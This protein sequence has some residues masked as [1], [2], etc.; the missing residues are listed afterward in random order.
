MENYI[1]TQ[2]VLYLYNYGNMHKFNVGCLVSNIAFTV[3]SYVIFI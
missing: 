3:S 1:E 2:A